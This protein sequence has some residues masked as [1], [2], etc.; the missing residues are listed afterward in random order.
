MIAS[1]AMMC[2][3]EKL[4]GLKII[5]ELNED[6]SFQYLANYWKKGHWSVVFWKKDLI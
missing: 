4:V 2:R 1:E 5:Y 6:S 3:M